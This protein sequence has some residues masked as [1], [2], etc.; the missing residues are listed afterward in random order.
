MGLSDPIVLMALLE[1]TRSA[2]SLSVD[3]VIQFMVGLDADYFM[4]EG[5]CVTFI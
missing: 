3:V 4:A 1:S 5:D 2:D